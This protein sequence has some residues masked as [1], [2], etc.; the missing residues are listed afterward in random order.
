MLISVGEAGTHTQ[1]GGGQGSAGPPTSRVLPFI[2]R[3]PPSP[4]RAD[5]LP[6]GHL[7]P[8][9]WG[10]SLLPQILP[11]S[12]FLPAR[13]LATPRGAGAVSLPW[14][15]AWLEKGAAKAPLAH[16]VAPASEGLTA[17]PLGPGLAR[18]QA[19][20]PGP[21]SP[22]PLPGGVGIGAQNF[23]DP[24]SEQPLRLPP[25]DRGRPSPRRMEA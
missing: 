13:A 10:R 15:R 24:A 17:A 4:S 19:L 16:R 8:K 3:C 2:A 23:P 18:A 22:P 12:K 25:G 6:A 20:P 7:P 5:R 11:A 1:E 9:A 21:P 14:Q